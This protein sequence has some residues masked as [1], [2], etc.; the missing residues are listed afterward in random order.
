MVFEHGVGP[1][2]HWAPGISGHILT[3]MDREWCPARCSEDRRAL[4]NVTH[5]ARSKQPQDGCTSSALANTEMHFG[6]APSL[7][8]GCRDD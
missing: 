3:A 2:P 4:M 6:S 8:I 5:T 1:G 7:S